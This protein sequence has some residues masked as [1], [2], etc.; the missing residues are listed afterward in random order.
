LNTLIKAAVVCDGCDI[1]IYIYIYI[2]TCN[3]TAP[4][5]YDPKTY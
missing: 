5:M 1:Y 2:Y 4:G 3:L